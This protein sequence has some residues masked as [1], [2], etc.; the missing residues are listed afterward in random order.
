MHLVW[1]TGKKRESSRRGYYILWFIMQIK[2]L[3]DW[4]RQFYALRFYQLKVGQGTMST[5][6]ERK[7]A[8]MFPK[9]WLCRAF[10]SQSCISTQIPKITDWTTNLEEMSAVSRHLMAESIQKNKLVKLLADLHSVG[11]LL[12]FSKDIELE[13]GETEAQRAS[14]WWQNMDQDGAN[15]LKDS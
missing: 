9:Y 3:L 7:G 10:T 14:E 13:Y 12:H 1:T 6:L 11:P 2:P 15:K 5:F 8:E 4:T